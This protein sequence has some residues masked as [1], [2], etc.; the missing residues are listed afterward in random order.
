MKS[1]DALKNSLWFYVGSGLPVF[2]I[3][4]RPSKTAIDRFAMESRHWFIFDLKLGNSY[5][6]LCLITPE[7]LQCS[8]KNQNITT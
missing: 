4:I 8:K 6:I 7:P 2:A 5:R 3:I 1:F